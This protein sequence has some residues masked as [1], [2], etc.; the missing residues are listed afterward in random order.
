MPPLGPLQHKRTPFGSVSGAFVL[1]PYNPTVPEFHAPSG[2][3]LNADRHAILSVGSRIH[4]K[5]GGG[6]KPTYHSFP[7]SG[8]TAGLML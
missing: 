3:L 7:L 4:C 5:N 6:E 8:Y 1:Y 2:A